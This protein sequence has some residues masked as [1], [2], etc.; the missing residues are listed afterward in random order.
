MIN[1][2]LKVYKALE[3]FFDLYLKSLT[4]CSDKWKKC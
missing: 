4:I 3:K 1:K 2:I